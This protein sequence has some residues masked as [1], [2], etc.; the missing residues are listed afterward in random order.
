MKKRMIQCLLCISMT[1]L[2]AFSYGTEDTED[3]KTCVIVEETSQ[4]DEEQ[5]FQNVMCSCVRVQGNNHY[6]SGS[7]FDFWDEDII[8][9]TNRHVIQYF[10]ENSYVTFFDGRKAEAEVIGSSE[11]Y[12]VGFLAVPIEKLPEEVLYEYKSVRIDISQYDKLT[13]NDCF[14]MIDMASDAANPQKYSGNVVEIRKYLSDYDAEMFYGDAYTKPGMS[15]C[16]LFDI[17]GNYIAM[18]SGGTQYLEVAAV[19]A[20]VIAEEY[21][22]IKK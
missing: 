8:V 21:E 9:V 4:P 16:G 15:G 3:L 7:I 10:D 18:L 11:S 13:K 2:A 5:A 19:P 17:Y 20:D 1:F 6:G 22:K 12:D 14:F